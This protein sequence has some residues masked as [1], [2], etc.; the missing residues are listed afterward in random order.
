MFALQNSDKN[1]WA[2]FAYC[3]VLCRYDQ[4]LVLFLFGEISP[5]VEEE[6]LDCIA[7][8]DDLQIIFKRTDK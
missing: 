2:V 5:D 1:M 3:K 8:K 7:G 6:R 4:L